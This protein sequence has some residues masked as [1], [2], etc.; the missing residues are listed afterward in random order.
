MAKKTSRG[1]TRI[2]VRKA[3]PA[4]EWKHWFRH[5]VMLTLVLGV[6]GCGAYLQQVETAPILPI[7][8][9]TVDGDFSHI[10]KDALVKAVTPFAIGGFMS[11]DVAR[12]REAGEAIPW[13]KVIQVKRVW[14]DS[15]HL[16]V[17]EQEAIALW[18]NHALVNNQGNLF[19]P[20]K[21]SF[22]EGL[23]Q[24]SGPKGSSRVV[25]EQFY[26][27]SRRVAALGLS[28]Q[29]VE[30]NERRAWTIKLSNGMNVMLGRTDSE[31]RLQRFATT[32]K[33]VLQPYQE[34]ITAVDM[35][36]TNGLSVA[37]VAGHKHEFNGTI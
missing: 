37:W 6:I 8:H 13:V 19:F 24:L 5:G 11:V 29:E 23:V 10:D 2:P 34:D 4:I 15:L 17:E 28:V 25:A 32:F 9:V 20:A 12:L 26:E 36:Y 16:V 14:P 3:R 22:P 35:R 33:A 27:V 30:M 7:L 18:G 1:A 21:A 31:Q